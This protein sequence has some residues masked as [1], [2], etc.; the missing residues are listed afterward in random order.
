MPQWL[1]DVFEKSSA[2]MPHGHC[3]FWLPGLLWLHVV[4]DI[5]IGL[6]Y[7]GIS[8]ILVLLV[9]KIRLPFGPLAVAF[10]LFIGLC[11][12]THFMAVWTVW[13]PDYWLAGII[14]GA[15]AAASV[16]TAVGLFYIRPQV[17]EVVHAARLSEERRI[18]LESTNA[19]LG[20]LYRKIKEMD[21]LKTQFFANVSHELRTPLSLIVGPAEHLLAGENLTAEQKRQLTSINRN[22]KSLLKQVND[23]LDVARLEEGKMQL[24]PGP[25][26]V[27]QTLQRVAAQFELV[28]EQRHIRYHVKRPESL[29]VEADAAML[30]RVMVN[31]LANAFKFTPEDGEIQVALH[32]TDTEYSFSVSDTGPGVEPEQQSVIFERFRQADGAATRRHGGTGLG[33]AIANDFVKLH[34]G[35]IDL[36]STFGEGSTFVVRLPRRGS[37]PAAFND[38][39]RAL[40]QG[41]Q[42]A[43]DGVLGELVPELEKAEDKDN[44]P[45]LPTILVVE[46]TPQMRELMVDT[47]GQRYNVATA[48]DGLIGAEKAAALLPDLVVTDIMMPRMSGDQLVAK[49]RS[50]KQFNNLPILLLSAKADDDLRIHLLKNGAQDYLTKPFSPQELLARVHNL[51]SVKRAGDALRGELASAS[52]NLEGLAH[53]LTSKHKQLQLAFEATE[54][55]REQAMRA[56]EVKSHFLAMVSHELRTPL[57]TIVMSAQLLCR[58]AERE[59]AAA[60]KPRLERM[61]RAAD[62]LSTLVEGI[63]EYTRTEG[64]KVKPQ[65]IAVDVVELVNEVVDVAQLQVASPAVKL[66]VEPPPEDTATFICDPRLLRV[67]L[68]NLVS[69]AL[70]FTSEGDVTVALSCSPEQLHL[71]VHDTGIGIAKEDLTRVFLPFEQVEPVQRKSIPGVGL[72]LALTKEL[73]ELLNGRIEVDSEVG[74]GSTFRVYLP[75]GESAGTTG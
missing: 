40:D 36:D 34:G 32:V 66:Q 14:K 4:S 5:L 26:D 2:F 46:D 3:Y 59:T 60:L 69:N 24:Q 1:S 43:V 38:S 68:H 45:N 23:L 65:C 6:A 52:N 39:S 70:K 61:A 44:D 15:T 63:L 29:L 47:L 9:R 73:V 37:A 64:G 51:V 56:S 18:Q 62:Q 71:A 35:S 74:K 8:L 50:Q 12:L 57:S 54:V 13:H 11:G 42:I 27:S 21:E 30:E 53:D 48:E 72:G 49:L 19:E 41:T 28:A 25:M 20:S 7:A 16:A 75:A 58:Q 67:I 31:L 10:G 55:A 17:E 33:L 22:G